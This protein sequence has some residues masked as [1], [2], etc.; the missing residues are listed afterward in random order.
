MTVIVVS[1]CS[2]DSV[3]S[4]MST[5]FSLGDCLASSPNTFFLSTGSFQLSEETDGR[6]E[7]R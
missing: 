2:I 4:R 1:T 3:L 5:G 7:D 6:P